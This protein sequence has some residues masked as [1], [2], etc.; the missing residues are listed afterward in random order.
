MDSKISDNGSGMNKFTFSESRNEHP[1]MHNFIEDS[2]KNNSNIEAKYRTEKDN[3]YI[4]AKSKS[5]A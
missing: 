5:I 1:V 2:M 4:R 3:N